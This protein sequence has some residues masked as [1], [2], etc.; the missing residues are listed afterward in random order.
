M[1]KTGDLLE[2]L[3]RVALDRTGLPR[4]SDSIDADKAGELLGTAAEAEAAVDLDR[5]TAIARRHLEAR[6]RLLDALREIDRQLKAG[7]EASGLGRT[8]RTDWAES[9]LDGEVIHAELA[10][11]GHLIDESLSRLRRLVVAVEGE[12]EL[13]ATERPGTGDTADDE[14]LGS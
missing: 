14:D 3:L 9:G 13:D 1:R 10:A 12:L 5:V 11:V 6:G 8:M 4:T 2:S 7:L